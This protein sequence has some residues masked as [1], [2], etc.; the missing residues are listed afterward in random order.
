[1]SRGWTVGGYGSLLF[2]MREYERGGWREEI[3]RKIEMEKEME[4]RG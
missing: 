4:N 1:M 2:A 3:G